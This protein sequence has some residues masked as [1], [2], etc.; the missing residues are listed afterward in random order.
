MA[1]IIQYL[2]T[3]A[4][5][6]VMCGAIAIVIISNGWI[7]VD[8]QWLARS[9]L[10][11]SIFLGIMYEAI[12]FLTA[13][14]L[15]AAGIHLFMSPVWLTQRLMRWPR[16]AVIVG[17]L[18]GMVFP[19]C[20]CGSIPAA[21]SLIQR[22]ASP[23]VGLAFALAAPVVNPIV[24]ISTSVAFM[25]LWGW[26]FVF[27]RFG[28]TILIAVMTAYAFPHIQLQQTPHHEHHHGNEEIPLLAWLRH[29]LVDWVDMARYLVA[30]ALIA[31][32]IQA[33]VPNQ[34]FLEL[35]N[36]AWLAVPAMM[37]LAVVM[38][39][40]STVDSFVALSFASTVSP[41]AVMAFLVFGP[42][43]DLKSVPML[44][45]LFGWRHVLLLLLFVAALTMVCTT[46]LGGLGWL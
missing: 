29:A 33:F 6:A 36:Q 14:S 34:L 42:I 38:S 20:E 41:A 2:R 27:W 11:V 21:R 5:T 32:M 43:I 3:T 15:V 16:L 19:V 40:C 8:D 37:L 1:V 7:V 9:E 45:A 12:P 39:I 28:L 22:G 18:M 17:S 23:Q 31:A 25:A 10:F 46:L 24:L 35:A 44:A 4:A 26:D 30:G 13:G